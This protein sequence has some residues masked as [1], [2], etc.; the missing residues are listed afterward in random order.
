MTLT[1]PAS[2]PPRLAHAMAL[3]FSAH[4]AGLVVPLLTVPWLARILGPAGWA[5]VLVAQALANWAILVLEFGFDLAGTRD[6]AQAESHHA[7]SRTAASVQRARLLLTP[8]VATGVVGAALLLGHDAPLIAGTVGF[9]VARGLSP[10]WF[11]QGKQRIKA[12]ALI[13]TLGKLLP[14][15]AMFIWVRGVDDGW[16]VVALQAVGAGVATIVLT[17]RVH[18]EHALPSV[19]NGEALQALRGAAPMFAARAASGLYLQ[20]NTLILSLAAPA[21]VVAT[22]G[23]AERIV[24]AA[25][26]LLNPMTQALFPRISQLAKASPVQALAEIRRTLLVLV[27]LALCGAALI[28]LLGQTVVALLLGP[29]YTSSVAVLRLLV[30]AFPLVAAGTVLGIYWALPWRRERLFLGAVLLGGVVN[31]TLA[32]LLVPQWQATGMALAVIAAESSVTAF[33]AV[34]FY[35]STRGVGSA[36]AV[37]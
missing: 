22:Y 34:A 29:S 12:A 14:A 23:G 9:V 1:E 19:T 17:W 20:A 25:I 24:R 6:V 8:L 2:R 37:R 27:G 28:A 3:L 18:R 13:D 31:L 16:R 5:P 35:R 32:A 15:A 33:L 21:V 7:M 10:Y 11:F 30:L 26:N 36:G 4:A